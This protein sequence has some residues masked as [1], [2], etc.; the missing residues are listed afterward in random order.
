[1]RT[2]SRVFLDGA[3]RS[4]LP[5]VVRI[6]YRQGDQLR[7][8]SLDEFLRSTR[9]AAFIVIKDGSIVCQSYA[10]GYQRD[11]MISSC[12]IAK[13]VTSAL[14]GIAIEEGYIGSVDDSMVSY[15][16]EL[17]GKGLDGVTLLELLTMSAGIAYRHEDERPCYSAH[18]LS[19][20]I[21]APATP[22]AA[23]AFHPRGRA[24]C[25]P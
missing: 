16:P 22:S 18:C 25:S 11:S 8:E 1:M 4:C 15:L 2:G 17:R 20:T 7:E 24:Q 6:Q 21:R 12:S 19:T 3:R 9:T 5:I 23:R 14:V 13:S 10:N